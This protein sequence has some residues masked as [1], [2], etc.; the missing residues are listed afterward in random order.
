MMAEEWAPVVQP[1]G[2]LRRQLAE[3]RLP[4]GL[5]VG[6]DGRNRCML[7]PFSSRTGR[8]QPSNS[9]FIFGQPSWLRGLIRPPPGYALAYIDWSQQEFALGAALSGD[10]AMIKAYLSDDPYLSFGREAGLIPPDGTAQTHP[11]ERKRCKACVLG[12]QFCMGAG[13]LALRI[14]QQPAH[15]RELLELHRRIY[16]KYWE[17]SDAIEA[18]G[19]LGG[20]VSSVFCWPLHVGPGANPRS[21]RNHVIQAN[22]AEMLRLACCLLTE[23]GIS[24]CALVHDAILIE[25]PVTE[26]DAVCGQAQSAMTEAG[27]IVTAGLTLRTEHQIVSE[28]DRLLDKTTRPVWDRVSAIVAGLA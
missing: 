12:T 18:T 10:P 28:H 27:S 19:M 15:A 8:N 9:K 3:L 7:S 11:L 1:V 26:I 13:T 21:I 17:W 22:G 2:E 4:P 6:P 20:Q 16:S 23:Q 24:V 5:S 25:A 14:G